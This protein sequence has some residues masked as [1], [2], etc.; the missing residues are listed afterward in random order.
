M[1][2]L[3]S[4]TVWIAAEAVFDHVEQRAHTKVVAD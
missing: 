4:I 1:I 3:S 2:I